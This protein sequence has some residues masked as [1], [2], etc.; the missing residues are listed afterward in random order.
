MGAVWDSDCQ[1]E[2]EEALKAKASD[3]IDLPL[4]TLD[5]LIDVM[6]AH[7]ASLDHALEELMDAR[8]LIA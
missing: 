3:Q 5:R 8:E 4:I 1:T 7:R 6:L 2:L